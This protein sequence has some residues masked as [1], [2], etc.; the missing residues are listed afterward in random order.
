[1]KSALR[2]FCVAALCFGVAVRASAAENPVPDDIAFEPRDR[3]PPR[4]T[5]HRC[6]LNLARSKK[7]EG[8]FPAVVCI[9]GGGFRAGHPRELR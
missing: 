3:I 7:G 6:K 5:E 9:H 2:A 8:P 4:Q 1:M